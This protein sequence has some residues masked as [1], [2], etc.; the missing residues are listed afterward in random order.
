MSNWYVVRAAR[1]P[2]SIRINRRVPPV[3]LGLL[4]ASLAVAIINIGMGEYP[5][6]P[7]DVLRAVLGTGAREHDFIVNTLRLPRVLVA[8]LVGSGLATA[9]SILQGVTRN[10]LAAPE[11]VGV[12]AGAN[13]AAAL[14]IVFVPNA[15]WS[16]L[17][18]AAFA[19]AL[20]AAL[21]TYML[22][23]QNG[24][25]PI[26][27]ILVGIGVA[28]VGS[29]LVSLVISTSTM[30]YRVSE[31][32][33]WITGSVYGRGWVQL[34][35]IAVWMA[36]LLPLAFLLSRHLN[37]LNLGEDIARG[38]GGSVERLKALLL[39][40]AVGLAAASVATA[41]SISF[42]GLMAPHIARRLVGGSHGALL[43]IAALTGGLIVLSADLIG[44]TLFA[45]VE[46][47]CGIITAAV[48]APYFIYLLYRDRNA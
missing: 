37:A 18:P 48:G 9:G 40:T 7:A 21:I 38:L 1:L 3:A 45:P 31:A 14:L 16:A 26:R 42:V 23:W 4:L 10:P 46:I 33:L 34:R 17:P 11:V 28:A 47:P 29:A 27:L 15:P 32:M 6:A 22:A 24:G 30:I 13:L 44:R 41:G 35:P 19:G 2:V 36:V 39:V 8:F 5:M 20:V 12:S 25:Q 43:P